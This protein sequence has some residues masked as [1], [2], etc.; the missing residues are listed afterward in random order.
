MEPAWSHT[1]GKTHSLGS[2]APLEGWIST[3]PWLCNESG[4][5]S[6]STRVVGD[7]FVKRLLHGRRHRESVW[8]KPRP[9][10]SH[11]TAQH[12]APELLERVC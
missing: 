3:A 10:T 6:S 4:A 2:L 11:T 5:Q 9:Q 12:D 8:T 7:L 1:R